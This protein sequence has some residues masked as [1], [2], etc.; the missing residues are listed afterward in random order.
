VLNQTIQHYSCFISYS[1]QDEEFAKRL[2][3]YLQWFAPDDR[4][5]AA[6]G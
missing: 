4:P 3:A 5:G 1:T 2:H 6:L